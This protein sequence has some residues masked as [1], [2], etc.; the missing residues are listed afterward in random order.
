MKSYS[1]NEWKKEKGKKL[2]KRRKWIICESDS[3]DPCG[4]Y[5]NTLEKKAFKKEANAE[6]FESIVADFQ[7]ERER[8]R[9]REICLWKWKKQ[10]SR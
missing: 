9:R 3:S 10:F 2:S 4:D 7:R 6:V 1:T 8:A 5:I